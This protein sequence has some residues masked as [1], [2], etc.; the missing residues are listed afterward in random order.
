MRKATILLTILALIFSLC[1]CTS[2]QSETIEGEAFQGLT[3][4]EQYDLGVRYL[5]EG[6][7]EEAIIAFTAAIEIDPKQVES[8]EK[9]ADVYLAIDDLSA[10]LQALQDGFAATG[11]PQ[12]QARHDELTKSKPTPSPTTESTPIPTLEPEP[13]PTLALANDLYPI[14]YI[15]LTVDD[16]TD[17][18][19]EDFQYENNW[20][21]GAAKPI[22]Y[23]DLRIP[24]R[25]YY[26]D[27]DLIGLANGS[28][29]IVFVECFPEKPGKIAEIAPG[30]SLQSNS[31]QLAELG[32]KLID[33]SEGGYM[34]FGATTT[35]WV[36]Y[37]PTIF[38]TFHWYDSV[39]P[40][41]SPARNVL[42]RS[43]P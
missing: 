22:Y 33:D 32:Y 12:L 3:W 6:N 26:I 24:V 16:L 28:E 30:I 23:A 37:S 36:E 15:G 14:D 17:L 43:K 29:Q 10:A 5:S 31:I 41:S 2:T 9:L 11:D 21:L 39:D 38:I 1:A 4:Q 18:W 13:T 19:G 40:S 20:F 34:E 25:F 27:S 42:I 35:L 7:Y 8:Y